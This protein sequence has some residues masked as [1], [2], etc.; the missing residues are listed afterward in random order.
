MLQETRAMC[1]QECHRWASC[2]GFC[3]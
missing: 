1:E 3:S 2:V